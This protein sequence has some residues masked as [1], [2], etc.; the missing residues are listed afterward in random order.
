MSVLQLVEITTFDM[1]IGRTDR[2]LTCLI[3]T[4]REGNEQVK[5]SSSGFARVDLP[6]AGSL[7][8]P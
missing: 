5:L 4:C 8:R 6:H 1:L 3:S 2:D 7:P